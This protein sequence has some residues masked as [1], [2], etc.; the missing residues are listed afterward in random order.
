MRRAATVQSIPVAITVVP[1]VV[2]VV[3]TSP[4]ETNPQVEVG[5]GLQFEAEARDAN[6]AAI[7]GAVLTWSA[8]D[9]TIAT[10]DASGLAVGRSPGLTTVRAA[11][12]NVISPQVLLRVVPATQ[13]PATIAIVSPASPANLVAGDSLQFIAEVRDTHG[14]VIPNAV[15]AWESS[16]NNI[17]RIAFSGMALGL[18]P[19]SA[20][21]RAEI[22]TLHSPPVRL[23]VTAPPVAS[24]VITGPASPRVAVSASIQFTAEARDALGR[25]IAGATFTWASENQSVAVIAAA[26][27]RATGIALGTSNI[28]ATSGGVESPPVLLTVAA[29]PP[30]YAQI[31]NIWNTQCT[32][33]HG[34]NG[35]PESWCGLVLEP[36]RRAELRTAESLARQTGRSR[37]QL[38]LHQARGSLPLGTL[39]AIPHA[40]RRRPVGHAAADGARLDRSRR[41]TLTK[42]GS[43]RRVRSQTGA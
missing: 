16:D 31:Q 23:Q 9:T 27:G 34:F 17:A 30:S 42:A 8:S 26:S 19:G 40:G 1:R 6:G 12:G 24:V 33:C 11:S 36:G 39:P 38:S 29:P 13:I 14:A 37:Q 10:L 35:Q 20:D 43:G 22:D 28:R 41:A 3:I 21:I 15:V 7:P 32:S 25:P 4:A 5:S 2:S 18:A